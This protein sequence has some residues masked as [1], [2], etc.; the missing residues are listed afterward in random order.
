MQM[1]TK[2]FLKNYILLTIGEWEPVFVGNL[3]LFMYLQQL[4]ALITYIQKSKFLASPQVRAFA[5]TLVTNQ[6]GPLAVRPGASGAQ[7]VWVDLTIHLAAVLL[8]GNQGIIAPLQQLALAPANMQVC[9]FS[10][11]F[12]VQ[13]LLL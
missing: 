13:P 4:D 12:S 6:L 2:K 10:A 8:C 5:S 3:Y 1:T 7:C 9:V 11:S